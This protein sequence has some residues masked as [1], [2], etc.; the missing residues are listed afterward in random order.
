MF[1][2]LGNISGNATA[3]GFYIEIAAGRNPLLD[4]PHHTE[5][6]RVIGTAIGL[7]TFC[8]A[9]HIFTRRGG[10]WLSNILATIK[11][12]MLL[13]LAVLG[14]VHAGGRYLQSKPGSINESPVL[15]APINITT[16]LINNATNIN[17]HQAFAA[18]RHDLGS[19]VE[20]LLFVLFAYTGYEQPFYVLTEV[21]QPKRVFPFYTVLGMSIATV[22]YM[23]MNISYFFVV[24]KEA[25]TSVPSNTID[26]AST[27]LHYLFDSSLGPDTARRVTA[28]LICLSVFGNVVVMTFT[29]ARVKQEIAKEA[30]LP[31]SLELATGYTTPF[32]W[33]RNRFSSASRARRGNNL[34][35]LQQKLRDLKIDDPLEKSPVPALILHWFTSVLLIAITA[36][37]PPVTAY[38]FLT[39]LYAFVNCMVVGSLISGGLLYLKIHSL[40]N[41]TDSRRWSQ[42]RS[43]I[44]PID[45]LH[46]IIY[47][48]GSIFLVGA[49]FV[50]PA[51]NSPFAAKIEGYPWWVLPTVGLAS[52]L[53]GV[54]WWGGLQFSFWSRTIRLIVSRTPVLDTDKYGDEVVIAELIEHRL[55]SRLITREV[56]PDDDGRYIMR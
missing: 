55:Q 27:F 41:S 46:V 38:S 18:P 33:L 36:M 11:V 54:I 26:M 45:P 52:L 28:G 35:T 31:Y 7:L 56:V 15:N 23:L 40:M 49:A 14:F 43:Y 47:F 39:A 44:P 9:F 51:L 19:Y 29:A 5:R 10:I 2:F 16:P 1:I 50:P 8:A 22:L 6:A 21:R 4:D 12:I 53:L 24:P 48:M 25:Y 20:S 32:A 3:F 34:T 13:V 17:F 37:L 42:V 30:I